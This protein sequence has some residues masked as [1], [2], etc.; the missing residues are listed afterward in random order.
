MRKLLKSVWQPAHPAHGLLGLLLWCVWFVALYA[1]LSVSCA[2]APPAPGLGAFNW[3]NAALLALTLMT[4][5]VLL[6]WGGRAWR[7]AG[8]QQ[9]GSESRMLSRVGAGVH[10]LSAGA[11]LIVALPAAFLPPC[12]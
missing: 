2:L 11:A 3:L 10:W 5:V 9:S 7:S 12:L 1:T 4:V 6:C 8:G